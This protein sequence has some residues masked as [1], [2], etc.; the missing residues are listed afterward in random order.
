M[1]RAKTISG[2][3]SWLLMLTVPV[4][5]IAKQDEGRES[6]AQAVLNRA[7]AG[8]GT[9]APDDSRADGSVLL[10]EGARQ[11]KGRIWIVT[12]GTEQCAQYLRFEGETSSKIFS[13]GEMNEISRGKTK[14]ASIEAAAS[15]Q[16]VEFPL[17]WL[18]SLNKEPDIASEYIGDEVLSGTAVQHI[19]LWNTFKSKP[20][21]EELKPLTV[22]ELWC[23]A[24]TGLPIQ[25]AYERR[26]GRGAAAAVKLLITFSSWRQQ[27][28]IKYPGHIEESFNGIPWISITIDNIALGVGLTDADFSVERRA[29]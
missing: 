21:L 19:R 8:M 29:K 11:R 22:K 1:F 9:K 16:C 5:V 6:K 24:V 4:C 15:G 23:D 3:L 7:I 18:E 10:V 2:Q 17:A 12:R 27:S 26:D 14:I 20:G 25:A 13:K 28:G